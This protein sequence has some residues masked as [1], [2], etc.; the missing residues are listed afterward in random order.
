MGYSSD[1]DITT[2]EDYAVVWDNMMMDLADLDVARSD[3]II[4]EE[5]YRLGCVDATRVYTATI[6]RLDSRDEGWEMI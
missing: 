1:W 6:D 3:G 4:G 5:E 2:Q